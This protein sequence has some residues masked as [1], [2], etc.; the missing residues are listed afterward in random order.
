MVVGLSPLSDKQVLKHTITTKNVDQTIPR[1]TVWKGNMIRVFAELD[2]KRRQR[3][4]KR[5]LKE[6]L[7]SCRAQVILSSFIYPCLFFFF[8]I[9]EFFF[10]ALRF[11]TYRVCC[12]MIQWDER[13][14]SPL[15][16]FLPLM[17]FGKMYTAD[18]S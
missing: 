17:T 4:G 6:D 13:L 3:F 5:H 12:Q 1:I 18:L 14:Q 10:S 9:F 15:H 8:C 16:L 11:F 2:R 7:A